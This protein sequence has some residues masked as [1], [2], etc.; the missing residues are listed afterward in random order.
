MMVMQSCTVLGSDGL[1]E[2]MTA[3]EVVDFVKHAITTIP[4][5]DIA[6]ALVDEAI[7]RRTS[8]NVTAIIIFL[9]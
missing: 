6:S 8:D 1:Y 4:L 2:N 9:V 7:N 3:Q 5:P